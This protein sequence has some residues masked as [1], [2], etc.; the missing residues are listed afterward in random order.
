MVLNYLKM[1]PPYFHSNFFRKQSTN[2]W[3]SSLL[4]LDWSIGEIVGTLRYL[5]LYE[6][7]VILLTGNNNCERNVQDNTDMVAYQR[8]KQNDFRRVKVPANTLSTNCLTMPLFIKDSRN[9][10]NDNSS[11]DEEFIRFSSHVYKYISV[12]DVFDTVL[13]LSKCDPTRKYPSSLARLYKKP[14]CPNPTSTTTLTQSKYEVDEFL[15]SNTTSNSTTDELHE[16]WT[17]ESSDEDVVVETYVDSGAATVMRCERESKFHNRHTTM[18]H[19]YN[20]Q[21]PMAIT[22]ERGLYKVI[23]T[24]Y[25]IDGYVEKLNVPIIVHLHTSNT[26]SAEL[27]RVY[28]KV[29]QLVDS[30]VSQGQTKNSYSSQFEM[31]VYP[32]LMPCANFPRCETNDAQVGE[33]SGLLE[34]YDGW[35]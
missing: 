2:T 25:Y 17:I 6:K 14:K 26:S 33:F 15:A 29:T 11:N 4:E 16:V 3:S 24:N 30:H 5:G 18:F 23:F 8:Y 32:W 22:Y 28:Q 34:K 27:E 1:K 20:V 13:D 31:P 9:N 21:K 10:K 12:M 19:Y 35:Q 7:T